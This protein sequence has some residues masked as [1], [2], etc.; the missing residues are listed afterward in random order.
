MANQESQNQL[1]DH[2]FKKQNQEKDQQ[3]A[4]STRENINSN[5]M[6]KCLMDANIEQNPRGS[7]ND[8]ESKEEKI[9]RQF[10]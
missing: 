5:N 3:A 7:I 9:F 1:L 6:I 10:I 8:D 2:V 4:Q